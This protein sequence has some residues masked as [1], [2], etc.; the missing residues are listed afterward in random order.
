MAKTD[1]D[2]TFTLHK[3]R[4]PKV[5]PGAGRLLGALDLRSITRYLSLDFSNVFSKGLTFDRMQ[6]NVSVQQ[7]NA[8]T[9]D[10]TIRTPGADLAIASAASASDGAA[11]RSAIDTK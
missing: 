2:L 3:G 7:G 9:R 1:G 6:A 10:L 8:Y 5:S 4:I 11:T